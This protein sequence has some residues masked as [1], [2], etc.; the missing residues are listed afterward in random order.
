MT[1]IHMSLSQ[2]FTSSLERIAMRNLAVLDHTRTSVLTG[3]RFLA[4]ETLVNSYRV[5]G[6]VKNML[7]IY[8]RR[9]GDKV[10]Q[11]GQ[12]CLFSWF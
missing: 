7:V 12:A 2:A 4:T 8:D 3:I 6:R 1:R 5:L 11:T 9:F 10:A